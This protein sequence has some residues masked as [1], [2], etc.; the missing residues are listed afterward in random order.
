MANGN[1]TST[2]DRWWPRIVALTALVLLVYETIFVQ[3][4]RVW[5]LFLLGSLA[6]GVPIAVLID[7]YLRRN[8]N[9]KK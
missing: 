6:T 2:W 4:D 7:A 9:G 8:G 1:A 3:Q 5:L